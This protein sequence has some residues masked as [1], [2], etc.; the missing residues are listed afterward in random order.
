[1][2]F[3]GHL[4]DSPETLADWFEA[5]ER[6]HR[7]M[8]KAIVYTNLEDSC[9][10]GNQDAAAR[11]DRARSPPAK[12]SAAAS[13]AIPEMLAAVGLP[14]LREWVGSSSR[15]SYLGH[16]FDRVEKLQKRIRSAEGEGRVSQGSDVLA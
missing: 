3:K 7:L 14:K 13:F 15:L 11:A 6:A 12:L 10:A 5:N 8:A 1:M 2:E 9:D 4:G 16:Y